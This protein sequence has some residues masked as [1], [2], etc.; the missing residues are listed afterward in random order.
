M[1]E[2]VPGRLTVRRPSQPGRALPGP[3]PWSLREERRG[4]L[5]GLCFA[6]TAPAGQPERHLAEV[7]EVLAAV[8]LTP[9]ARGWAERAFRLLAAAE[10]R[11]HGCR[12]EGVHFHGVGALDALADVAGACALLDALEP[13]AVRA[14]PPALGSGTV[15]TAHGRLPVPAPAVLELLRGAPVRGRELQGERTTPTGAALLRAWDAAWEPGPP[16]VVEAVGHGLGSRETPEG[17][18]L[19]RVVLE[20]VFGGGESLLELRVLVDDQSGEVV[21]AALEAFRAAGAVEAFALPAWAKKGRPAFEV[22]VLVPAARG[23]EFEELVYRHLGTLGMRV[24]PVSRR[25]RPR[26]VAERDGALGPMPWKIREDPEGPV[27]LKPEFEALR[28]R[29]EERGSTPREAREEL[30]ED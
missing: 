24:Q 27:A 18:N 7:L 17:P 29:A 15:A 1:S 14:T 5:R 11:V 2:T 20:R 23:G 19:L 28:R 26:T 6:V 13:A 12:P 22:C 30:R 25:R 8:P 9:R 3:P 21:G 10:A 16:A 4:G